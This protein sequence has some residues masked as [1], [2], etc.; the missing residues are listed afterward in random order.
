MKL[1][2]QRKMFALLL[3][4]IAVLFILVGFITYANAKKTTGSLIKNYTSDISAYAAKNIDSFFSTNISYIRQVARENTITS[5]VWDL[6][7]NTL[8][9]EKT[10][11]NNVDFFFLGFPDGRAPNTNMTERNIAHDEFFKLILQ[12]G[13]DYAVSNAL[14]SPITGKASIDIVSAVKYPGSPAH[15]L[16][17]MAID[18][19]RLSSLANITVGNAGFGFI[20]D[21]KGLVVAHPDSAVRM[22]LNVLDSKN[23]GYQGLDTA[24]K[25]M[26]GGQKGEAVIK[27]P[28]G[29][30]EH[31]FFNPLPSVQGWSFC[32]AVPETDLERPALGIILGIIVSF[33]ALGLLLGL[34]VF[35]VS[36]MISRSV[37]ETK[38]AVAELAKGEGDLTK[39][40]T[41]RSQDELGEMGKNINQF[42]ELI[43]SIVS[44]VRQIVDQMRLLGDE[45]QTNTTQSS[46][47]AQQISGNTKQI[48]EKLLNQSAGLSET[49]A[50]TEQINRNIQSFLNLIETQAANLTQSSASIE[51]MVANIN[52]VAKIT[53]RNQETIDLLMRDADVGKERLNGVESLIHQIDQAS[54]GMLEA[55]SIIAHIASQTNL[56]SMN[57]AIEAAHAGDAGKGFAV[58]ADEIRKLAENANEQSKTIAGVLQNV[59]K[60]VEETVAETAEAQSKFDNLFTGIKRVENQELEVKNAM[61]EQR[62][63][64]QQVLVAMK[65]L[66]QITQEIRSGSEEIRVGS[67]TIL[68]EM[69]RIMNGTQD[70][71][72]AS[73]EN[74][75][76][77]QEIAQA[78]EHIS[79][80][81]GKNRD[82]I[83]DLE[84]LVVRFRL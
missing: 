31:L 42:L 28:K 43:H 27:N 64:S 65:E 68:E 40:I 54:E 77:A 12:G 29:I 8:D 78:M 9:E 48:Q 74:S 11:N 21:N 25:R 34:L 69:G 7:K 5:M 14:V 53:I 76:G 41:V 59:K 63:G 36:R 72:T 1:S 50:T 46:A 19:V 16:V 38:N 2:I 39:R 79:K 71:E 49:L 84:N 26:I 80:L 4:P 56:L 20:V 24:G 18:L 60:L 52:S 45:L 70:I 73:S 15:G 13:K 62:Q 33:V 3:A 67:Q 58:V 81:T 30:T 66:N 44:S 10:Y 6:A 75:Q 83:K 57:A 23:S 37:G 51:E 55:N 17:G 47:S 32:V 35:F 82:S 22:T 61:E